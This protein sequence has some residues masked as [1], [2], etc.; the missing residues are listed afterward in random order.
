MLIIALQVLISVMVVA[1]AVG[2]YHFVRQQYQQPAHLRTCMISN[3]YT[4]KKA[5]A[6]VLYLTKIGSLGMIAGSLLF[7]V[8][9]PWYQSAA[10]ILLC[11]GVLS[12]SGASVRL[13][14]LED[15]L[16]KAG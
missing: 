5:R 12:G 13:A 8:W 2:V 9:C 6:K 3:D 11:A 10:V 16:Y 15:S 7:L 1:I 4:S 14:K